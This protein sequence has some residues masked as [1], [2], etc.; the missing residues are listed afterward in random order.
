MLQLW[1]MSSGQR[2]LNSQHNTPSPSPT[3]LKRRRGEG[4]IIHVCVCVYA[5]MHVCVF[6]IKTTTHSVVR[7][8]G[9]VNK[10]PCLASHHQ[11]QSPNKPP[12][13]HTLL[14]VF[15]TNIVLGAPPDLTTASEVFSSSSPTVQAHS[16][17]DGRRC[18][19]ITP[20]HG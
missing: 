2:R 1:Q 20:V 13:H 6:C 19:T 10:W 3:P 5:C 15:P 4:D 8:N 17:G 16:I 18:F 14:P 12:R 9:E 7:V 11:H